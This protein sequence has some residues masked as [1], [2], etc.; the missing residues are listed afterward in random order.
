MRPD[1]TDPCGVCGRPRA[2]H[3]GLLERCQLPVIGRFVW[4]PLHE[5]QEEAK[6]ART[7]LLAVVSE[8]DFV[9]SGGDN[10]VERCQECGLA[11]VGML[12]DALRPARDFVLPRSVIG[13]DGPALII[14]EGLVPKLEDDDGE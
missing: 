4:K 9:L 2:E 3:A 12:R 11:G 13:G 10:P 1:P 7:L 6:K 5:A 14:G 8:A